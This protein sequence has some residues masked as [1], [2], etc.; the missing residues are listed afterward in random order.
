MKKFFSISLLLGSLVLIFYSS[1]PETEKSVSLSEKEPHS[2]ASASTRNSEGPSIEEMSVSNLVSTWTQLPEE[3]REEAEFL[4]KMAARK[5]ARLELMRENP[6][7]FLAGTP[8]IRQF[9]A[10]PS[11]LKPY[12]EQPYSAVGD[13]R[14]LWTTSLS[15]DGSLICTHHNQFREGENRF[16]LLHPDG[17]TLPAAEQQAVNGW[18]L[19]DTLLLEDSAVKPLTA[20]EAT[21]A[22]SLFPEGNPDGVDPVTGQPATAVQALAGGRIYRFSDPALPEILQEELAASGVERFD[23]LAGN[24]SGDQGSGDSD[25]TPYQDDQIDV[26]FIRVDFPDFPGEPVSK[27]DLTTSLASVN[28]HIADYS[29][30]QAGITYTV[31][32]SVYR[33]P[34]D[35][36]VYAVND[37]NEGIQTDARALASGDYTLSNYDVIAVFFPNL[38]GVTNSQI[39]YGGLADIGSRTGGA[40]HWINGFNDIQIILH[41]FGHNYGLYHANYHHPEMQLPG[42]YDISGSLEYG[43]IFDTMGDGNAPEA[44]FNPLAKNYLQWLPDSKVAEATADGTWRIYRFDHSNALTHSTLALKVPMAG[45]TTY[46]VGHRKLYTSGSFNLA[47]AAYVV[48]ENMAE[49]RETSLIDMTPESQAA[50]ADDRKDAGLPVG[51]SFYEPS[52]GVTFETLASGGSSPSEWIDVRIR[53]DSRIGFR[54]SLVEVDEQA[55]T[56]SV[57]VERN[58][59]SS[60]AVSVEFASADD[61]ATASADYYPVSG[62]LNWA[63][64]DNADKI[65]PVSIRP[66]S[67]NEGIER[68]TLTLSNPSGGILDAGNTTMEIH[69]LDPGQRYRTFTPPFFNTTVNAVVPLPDGKVIIGGDIAGGIG[70]F[71]SIRHIARL[72]AD[73]SVDS[74]FVSGSGFNAEVDLIVRQSDGKLLVAGDF[75]QYNGVNCPGLVRLS[76]DGLLETSFVTKLGTGGNDPI[77]AIA[78][79]SDG[80][81]LVGGDFSS[82]NGNAAEGLIRLNTDG[83]RNTDNALALPFDTGWNTEI[84]SILVESDGKI[85]VGGSLAINWTGSGWRSGIARLNANG[86]RDSSFDPDAGAHENGDRTTLNRVYTIQKQADGKYLIGGQFTAYDENTAQHLARITNSGAFDASF[87]P[88]SIDEPVREGRIQANQRYV[89][90]GTF[91]TPARGVERFLNNGATDPVFYQQ[92]GVAFNT[93]NPNLVRVYTLAEDADGQLFLGGNFFSYQGETTRPVIRISGGVTPYDL[94]ARENFTEAQI[95]SGAADPDADPDSDNL[96]NLAEMAFGENPNVTTAAGQ[97][98]VNG[99]SGISIAEDSGNAYLQISLSKPASPDGPWY[100]AQF[101]GDLDTWSPASP[102]PGSTEIVIIENSATTFTVRD[103]VPIT[104]AAPRF[105]R[106]LLQEPE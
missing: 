19:A 8:S 64:G 71:D 11:E 42:D 14:S 39:T 21:A 30:G 46:W 17:E 68:L 104:P 105:G 69:L 18:L 52:A 54:D 74:S 58:F 92:S 82:F 16:T 3:S 102:T 61:T 41:E 23:W 99:A 4:L 43:D 32:D 103:T 20:E 96:I 15:P 49:N 7:A 25:A 12:V 36:A 85:M 45:D 57:V 79:E 63:D 29:Y 97:F 44:H 34:Q 53:F 51:S 93:A 24:R 40:D 78:Q 65:I 38:S 83:S 70:D 59:S 35:G 28:S 62:T 98:A 60:G 75:T 26:L 101:S 10:L 91:V 94:W 77:R 88:P 27:T 73:G 47:N 72:N 90:S 2:E 48:G 86:S 80:G 67:L 13:V 50:E 37:D 95:A 6:R 87:N 84:H 33:M 106:V 56:V 66:D 89:I 22:A 1:K 55:G 81:I 100:T 31:S 9:T 76:A 5:R